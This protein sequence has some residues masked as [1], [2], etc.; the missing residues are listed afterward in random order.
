[1]LNITKNDLTKIKEPLRYTGGE[2][3]EV[4]KNESEIQIRVALCYP[5]LYDV[6]M[7][8]YTTMY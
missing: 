7:N 5:N 4:I 6:G 8:N 2:Y 3:G 1:M